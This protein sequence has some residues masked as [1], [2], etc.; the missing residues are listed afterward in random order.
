[1]PRR[2]RGVRDGMGLPRHWGPGS[3]HAVDVTPE[4]EQ[5]RQRSVEDPAPL[6]ALRNV[7]LRPAEFFTRLPRHGKVGPAIAFALGCIA[8]STGLAWPAGAFEDGLVRGLLLPFAF[9]LVFFAI[10]LALTHATVRLL[11]GKRS[12]GLPASFRIAA[13]GQVSQLVN[14]LP[15]AG[16]TIGFIWGSVLTVIGVHRMHET[17]LRTAVAVVVLPVLLVGALAAAFFLTS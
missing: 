5:D 6:D 7:T 10:Y 11:I 14:W 3:A 16:L 8:L 12:H 13:Y 4:L 17:A 2:Y 1:M 9:D 15:V